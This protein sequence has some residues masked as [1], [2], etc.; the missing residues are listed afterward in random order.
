MKLPFT[1]SMIM[2]LVGQIVFAQNTQ[3]ALNKISGTVTDE[4]NLPIPNATVTIYDNNKLYQTQT[5][6]YGNYCVANVPNGEYVMFVNTENYEQ[7]IQFISFNKNISIN[8]IQDFS[9]FSSSQTCT[10]SVCRGWRV[11]EPINPLLR[12][13]N[14][15]INAIAA[16][17][18]GVDSRN[19]ETPS[20]MGARPENTAYYLDG[21]RLAGMDQSLI[22]I[23]K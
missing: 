14:Q 12:A 23:G 18:R 6:S 5:D 9:L 7:Q 13:P 17:M 4:I 16:Y 22:I 11:Q 19:G 8:S 15:N 10:M 20:I 3:T 21:V 1:L 2:L